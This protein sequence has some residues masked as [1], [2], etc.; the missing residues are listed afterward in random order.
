MRYAIECIRQI[1]SKTDKVILFHSATGKDSI[2]LLDLC[3]PHFDEV[4]CVYMYMVEGLEHIDKYIIWAKQRYPKARFISVPHYALTQYIKDGAFGCEQDPKQ[5]IK[6]LS[7]ITEDVRALTGIEWA[8]YGFKQTD[9]LNR[10]IMLRGYDMQMVNEPTKK[11]YPLSLYKNKDV[12]AYIK[13]KRLIP[14]LKY[15]NGQ[16]QG[17]DV[18]NIPFLMY[19]RN[20]YPQDLERVI[21]VFPEVEKILFDY[22]NYDPKYEQ[23]D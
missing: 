19:C 12:E 3:Y 11:A 22:L 16:S 5:R 8:I 7:D 15:G 20:Y 14:S 4:V 2:A 13:H 10:R 17:S 1:A 9:S 23:D 18:T 21:A 6:T